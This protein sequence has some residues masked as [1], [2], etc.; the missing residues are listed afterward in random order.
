AGLN[1][2]P[3]RVEVETGA[4]TRTLD[5][6]AGHDVLAVLELP[7]GRV[8]AR[9]GQVGQAIVRGLGL[10]AAGASTAPRPLSE[11]SLTEAL[12]IAP[13]G[14]WVI[15]GLSPQGNV[16]EIMAMPL[17]GGAPVALPGRDVVP[18]AGMA[19]SRAGDR[20]VWSMCTSRSNLAALARRHGGVA[21]AEP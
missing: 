17:E 15:A 7:D 9:L 10:Y 14:R 8:L 3:S 20:L 12:A 11:D 5:P 4:V 18:Y 21:A 2:G 6:P 19:L 16:P 1:S 13:D